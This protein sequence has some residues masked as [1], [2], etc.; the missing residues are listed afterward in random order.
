M[1]GRALA[2]ITLALLVGMF[3]CFICAKP[4]STLPSGFSDAKVADVFQPTALAFTPDGRVLA[5]T[6]PAQ[7]HVFDQSG[8]A[9][10]WLRL[11]GEDPVSVRERRLPRPARPARQ[12]P[13]YHAR[14][15]HSR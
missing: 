10:A 11:C 14:R 6:K 5:T 15:H 12:D 9:L 2:P 4:A 8:N 7:L 1:P 13:A 3:A